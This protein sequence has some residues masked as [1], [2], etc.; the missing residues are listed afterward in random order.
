MLSRPDLKHGDGRKRKVPIYI[1]CL[2]LN[3]F[4]VFFSY[5]GF[6]LEHAHVFFLVLG[7]SR[8]AYTLTWSSL[9]TQHISY[10]MTSIR[11]ENFTGGFSSHDENIALV[12]LTFSRPLSLGRK[13]HTYLLLG[14]TGSVL[15]EFGGICFAKIWTLAGL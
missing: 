4:N 6:F 11:E 12:W 10:L 9:P 1:F 13:S 8:H 2:K 3:E 15:N 7:Q 5:C 14:K